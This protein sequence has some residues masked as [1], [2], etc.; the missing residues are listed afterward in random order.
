VSDGARERELLLQLVSLRDGFD[1]L[2]RALAAEELCEKA[3]GVVSRFALVRRRLES[4][5]EREGVAKV[6][7]LGR[8]ANPEIHE[9]VETRESPEPSGT[10]LDVESDA[11]LHRGAVLRTGRV[12]TSA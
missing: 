10:I 5:L 8:V 4:A 7:S 11:F 12:V 6:D 9:I 3:R 1:R 2:E